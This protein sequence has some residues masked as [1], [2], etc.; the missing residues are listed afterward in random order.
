MKLSIGFKHANKEDIDFLLAL[1]K[2]TMTEHLKVAGYNFSEQDHLNRIHELFADSHIVTNNKEN[3]GLIKLGLL[4][5]RIHI[6]QFQI[7][8][9][10]HGLGI[11]SY[12]LD[13]VK[14]KAVE[15]KLPITLFVL[16]NNPVKSLYLRHGFYV[17]EQLE[18]EYKMRWDFSEAG[19]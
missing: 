15:H 17:E 14:K 4:A 18:K 8:P 3:V 7:L 6:R 16:L 2:A 11:G 10:L 19:K 12:V 1:R 5:D 13:I 9:S